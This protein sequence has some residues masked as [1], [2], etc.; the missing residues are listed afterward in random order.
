MRLDGVSPIPNLAPTAGIGKTRSAGKAKTADGATRK[1][2]A[3]SSG[4]ASARR[5]SSLADLFGQGARIAVEQTPP[6]SPYLAGAVAEP[7]TVP[8]EPVRDI[9]RTVLNRH[10]SFSTLRRGN[11]DALLCSAGYDSINKAR[12]DTG[13]L[14]RVF[15]GNAP[16]FA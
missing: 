6:L 16:I 8:G 7:Q 4:A 10:Y 12:R 11:F 13:A 3:E 2:S 1:K 15:A 14:L 5:L 9:S